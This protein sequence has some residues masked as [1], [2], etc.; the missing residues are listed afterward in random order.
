MPWIEVT[1]VW[2]QWPAFLYTVMN[3]PLQ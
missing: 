1:Q 3:L 2:V